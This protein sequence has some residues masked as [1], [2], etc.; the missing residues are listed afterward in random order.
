MKPVAGAEQTWFCDRHS[1]YA[2][3]VS[4]TDAEAFERG[5]SYPTPDGADGV[6]VGLGDERP[7]GVILYFRAK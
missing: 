3:L 4:K 5:D 1:M 6:I 2:T 7:G